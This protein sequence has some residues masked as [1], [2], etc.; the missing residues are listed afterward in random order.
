V[1]YDQGAA[2]L[3]VRVDVAIYKKLKEIADHRETRVGAL[4]TEWVTGAVD[5]AHQEMV[6]ERGETAAGGDP[7]P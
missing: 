7:A 3:V 4:L 5:G 2:Q 6:R 1:A